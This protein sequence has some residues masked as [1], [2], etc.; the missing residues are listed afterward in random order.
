M[1]VTSKVAVVF[2]VLP[3]MFIAAIFVT[4]LAIMLIAT[5]VAWPC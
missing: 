1:T 3:V 5:I 2:F 4:F